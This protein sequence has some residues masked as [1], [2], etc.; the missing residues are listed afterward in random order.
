MPY[1][2]HTTADR[3]R[4]LGAL[5]LTHI[6]QLF[7]DIPAALRA[8]ALDLPPPEPELEL[9]ARL[10]G[11]AA[12]NRTDLVSFLGAGV[13]RHWSPPAVDQLL[14]RGEWYTAYTPYQPEVSQGTLQ[15]IY[16]YQSLIGE[17]VDLDVVSAS[18]YD[19]AAAT[20]EAALMACRATRRERVLVSRSVHPH[21][22]A[23]LRTYFEGRLTL[24]EIP[25]LENG[26][27]AGTTDIGALETMLGDADH[28]VAGVVVANPDFLGLLEP[29]ARIGEL[30]HAA[31]ALFVAVIEPVSLAVLTPPGAYGADIAAG[32]GQPLGIAPQ[33]GGP[34]LGV[35]ATTDALVRQIPG[36]LV[37]M[38]TDL[39]GQR[40][41]V[42][43][44]RAREQ[45]IRRDKAASNICTNQALLALAAS[46]YLAAIGPHG[47]RDVAAT[48]AA[49]AAEL[50][51]GLAAIG[52]E[53][54]H[55]GAYLNEFAVRL[56]DA[57]TVHRRLIE[58]GFLA[59]LVLAD[60]EP[61]DPA[62]ADALLLCTTELTSS[63]DIA[64]FVAALDEVLTGRPSVGVETG[65]GDP[66]HPVGAAR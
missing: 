11:L 44:L 28:P 14:L 36:R 42:M 60:A 55:R 65:A 23:T 16:E 47:L 50:E 35:L 3:E 10:R 63:G 31:G 4:M 17:L 61:D 12:R 39:D 15:S 2:P 37:G 25:L 54:L 38:T 46:I 30:A 49:R 48:G 57:R 45:D 9:S 66:A 29:M 58:R 41:F 52:V 6:D 33:Y 59:G 26:D 43:T 19:G 8:S 20:A 1:G 24:E 56:P 5:G 7:D 34:Y 27:D 21:Y 51:A 18:H 62:L 40:A 64:R 22:R 13:Y 32:E 53:R